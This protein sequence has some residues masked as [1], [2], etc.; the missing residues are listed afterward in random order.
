MKIINENALL[1]L[2]FTPVVNTTGLTIGAYVTPEGGGST[3]A[4]GTVA[5]DVADTELTITCDFGGLAADTIYHLEVIGNLSD[6]NPLVLLP[7]ENSGRPIR[8][9]IVNLRAY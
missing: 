8:I 3:S 7:D 2:S 6:P 4:L 1:D 9:K 5:G